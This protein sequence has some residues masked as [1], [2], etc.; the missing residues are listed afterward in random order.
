M[1]E[2]FVKPI[3]FEL[4]SS[5]RLFLQFSIIAGLPVI[6]LLVLFKKHPFLILSLDLV[7]LVSFVYFIRQYALRINKS[8]IVKIRL[9]R[10]IATLFQKDGVIKMC[11]IKIISTA[12]EW[13]IFIFKGKFKKLLI[14]QS[15]TGLATYSAIRREVSQLNSNQ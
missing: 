6:S 8:S 14:D 2:L 13:V 12:P 5:S 4:K 9:H 15:S 11:P 7:I 10:G 3:I 1:S